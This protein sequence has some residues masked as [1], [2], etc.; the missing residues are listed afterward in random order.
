VNHKLLILIKLAEYVAHCDRLALRPSTKTTFVIP[1]EALSNLSS[2]DL[3]KSNKKV[4]ELFPKKEK[5]MM[6]QK[7]TLKVTYNGEVRRILLKESDGPVA[8]ESLQHTV[9]KLFAASLKNKEFD[10]C[11]KDED[12]DEVVVS[13][14]NEV[15]AAV[16][17]MTNELTGN[18]KFCIREKVAKRVGGDEI[19]SS[20]PGN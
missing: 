18:L 14:D 3:G 19:P 5:I 6:N 7:S 8:F 1:N 17:A 4:N 15:G 20:N 9:K 16:Y 10:I 11:W 2:I 12:E 13:S